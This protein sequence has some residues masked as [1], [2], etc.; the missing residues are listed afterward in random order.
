MSGLVDLL[1]REGKQMF[2]S[3]RLGRYS[4]GKTLEYMGLGYI[5]GCLPAKDQEKYAKPFKLDPVAL[6]KYSSLVQMVD[7]AIMMGGLAEVAMPL[8]EKIIP[9]V[10]CLQNPTLAYG[11]FFIALG[12]ARYAIA[13]ATKK[14]VL[15]P[16]AFTKLAANYALKKTGAQDKLIA[17]A[18]QKMKEWG[19]KAH[20]YRRL[21]YK[22]RIFF[23]E[24][25]EEICDNINTLYLGKEYMKWRIE[26]DLKAV[27]DFLSKDRTIS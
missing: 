24:L 15:S 8:V 18:E 7:G 11:A 16:V 17:T 20:G 9:Q 2:Y 14:P 12:S 22:A 3:E 25:G 26:E 6:T 10:H 27:K 4:F 23:R 21:N 13:L 19:E 5:L 1:K